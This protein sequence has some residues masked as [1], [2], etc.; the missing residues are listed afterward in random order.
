KEDVTLSKP[1]DTGL[2]DHEVES[3][4]EQTAMEVLIQEGLQTLRKRG[5]EAIA[6]QHKAT[7][8]VLHHTDQLKHAL[9]DVEVVS[10]KDLSKTILSSQKEAE[11][12]IT[13]AQ[14]A[15]VKVNEEVEKFHILIKE[16]E[17]AGAKE[18]GV[19]ASEEAAKVSYGVLN[20][21]AELQKAKAQDMVLGEYQKFFDESRAV[22][23]KELEEVMPGAAMSDKEQ[24]AKGGKT[25]L[26]AYARKRLEHLKQELAKHRQE[27]QKR[28]QQILSVQREEDNKLADIR[29]KQEKDKMMAEMDVALRK[30][31]SEMAAV[32]ES[33]VRQQLRRQAAA[34]SDH[35]AEVLRV[36]AA[37]LQERHREELEKKSNEE[38]QAFNAKL[39][40]AFSR[41]R[42][43]ESAIDGR[44]EIE[45]TNKRSQELWLACQALTSAIDRGYQKRRPLNH[46]VS[47]VYDCSPEDPV[48]NT[49]LEAIPPEALQKG[50]YNED[51]LTARFNQVR[52][53]CRRVAMVG[54]DSAGPWTFLLSYL[55][56]FFIFDKFDPRT[57]GELV[58]AEELDT[59]GLLARADYYI[60][61]GDLELGA[62]LVNQLTGEAR[63][64]AY[65]WLKET[66][67]LL[68]TRQAVRLLSSYAAAAAMG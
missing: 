18:A 44:A 11:D 56:S 67:I 33:D 27:E 46:E 49:V 23:R 14:E 29:L 22:L 35:L 30:K 48:V 12:A 42:G 58:D 52:R 62:R 8:A 39:T 36:Q 43:V 5:Q 26:L 16:A 50:V 21:T 66:R 19:R 41:L 10:M 68:E 60:K 51:N 15:Q 2:T 32:F 57:D 24:K 3:M 20:A 31:E 28:L 53:Q 4:V 13:G 9:E 37:E 45:K 47:A 17:T 25:V 64:L 34:Y 65:D 7:E 38:H 59:F 54:E 40:A 6:A 63:K 61:R 1:I 55:Q